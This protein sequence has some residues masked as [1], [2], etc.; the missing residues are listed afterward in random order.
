[1]IASF[2]LFQPYD[3]IAFWKMLPAPASFYAK[4]KIKSHLV[5]FWLTNYKSADQTQICQQMKNTFRDKF[6]CFAKVFH[7][8]HNRSASHIFK[9]T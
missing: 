1:M 2:M 4:H 7:A 9:L 5:S 3:F 6:C 8:R